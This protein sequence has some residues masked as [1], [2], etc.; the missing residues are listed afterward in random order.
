MKPCWSP[1]RPFW[2]KSQ[3]SFN[4]WLLYPTAQPPNHPPQPPTTPSPTTQP[5]HPHQHQ[6]HHPT[7]RWDGATAGGEGDELPPKGRRGLTADLRGRTLSRWG[8]WSE[9]QT[10]GVECEPQPEGSEGKP[11]PNGEPPPLGGAAFLRLLW[12]GR[13]FSFFRHVK[14]LIWTM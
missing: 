13:P 1:F 5:N 7:R 14:K 10:G 3:V 8:G 9:R 4:F 11:P 6:T 2:T 12:V